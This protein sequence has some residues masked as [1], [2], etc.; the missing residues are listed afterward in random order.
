MYLCGEHGHFD[1]SSLEPETAPVMAMESHLRHGGEPEP[2]ANPLASRPAPVLALGAPFQPMSR[3]QWPWLYDETAA[4]AHRISQQSI[5]SRQTTFLLAI[6]GAQRQV[7]NNA[8]SVEGI[9]E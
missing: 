2:T 1:A 8:Q 7:M 6:N 9:R 5:K 4:L 3:N